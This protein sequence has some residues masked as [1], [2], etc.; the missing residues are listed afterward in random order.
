VL[1]YNDKFLNN[2]L[3][4]FV[5]KVYTGGEDDPLFF[6]ERNVEDGSVLDYE[7]EGDWILRSEIIDRKKTPHVVI[8]PDYEKNS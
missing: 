8:D 5:G 2:A 1:A 6:V 3:V 4:G 7:V